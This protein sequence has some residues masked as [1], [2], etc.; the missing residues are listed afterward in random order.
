MTYEIVTKGLCAGY[1]KQKV[2]GDV[3]LSLPSG[4]IA[5]LAGP[6]GSGKTT[7]LKTIVGQL[8]R[9]EGTVILGGRELAEFGGEE[10]AKEAS[11]VLTGRVRPELMKCFDVAAA[12]RYPHTGRFGKLGAE[13]RRQVERAMEQLHV[14]E[15]ADRYFDTLSDGQKQRVLI[16]RALCQQPKL[17]VMDEPMNYLDVR[18]QLDL[19]DLLRELAHG[20]GMTIMLSL[21]EI[22]LAR[23]IA[24]V[25]LL[26][27]KDH[28]VRF[29]PAEQVLSRGSLKE[30]FSLDDKGY[31]CYFHD[32]ALPERKKD[33]KAAHIPAETNVQ[34]NTSSVQNTARVLMV[35]GTMSGVGKSLLAAG[36]CRIFAADGFRAAPFKSQNMALNSYVTEDGLEIGR[37]QAMQALAAGQKPVA[38]MNPVL[39]KP[40]GHTGSQVIV[41]GRVRGDME[42][43]EY[44][45]FRQKLMPEIIEAFTR[46]AKD[47]DIIVVEG[48]GSPAELN[49]KEGD[50]VNMGLAQLIDAPVLLVGDIDRGGIFAQ[51]LGTLELLEPEERR[52]VRGL[53]V[54]KFR[55]DPALFADGVRILEERSSLP[56]VGVVPFTELQL[57]DEDSLNPRFER[58]GRGRIDLAVVRFPRISNA[59]DFDVFEQSPEVSVRYVRT[60]EELRGADMIFLPGSKNT[61]D[62]LRWF[63][64]SGLFAAVREKAEEGTPLWG[65]C[66]G[67]Q[68]LGESVEDPL[69]AEAGGTA[70]GL[71]LLPVVT[72]LEKEKAQTQREG[73]LPPVGGMFAALS[74]KAYKGYEIHMGR[75]RFSDGADGPLPVVVER[76]GNIF[77]TYLHGVFDAEGIAGA[78]LEALAKRKGIR[79]DASLLPRDLARE[80]EFDRLEACLRDNLPMDVIYR[81]MGMEP[82]Q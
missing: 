31:E 52:R 22:R 23:K 24:D 60:P 54:N 53:I 45:A 27:R 73:V 28:V 38:D 41:N 74:Q 7:L 72:T 44:F 66:G 2:V 40:T 56:V 62:D 49:L 5:V 47:N 70:K 61:L 82:P 37:A 80:R 75:T 8:E 78:I 14:L 76:R 11:V 79:V 36:L 18:Y 69:A 3:S 20:Q 1:G 64:E 50:V 35:Q 34:K 51:L 13:D 32:G 15:Y 67:F 42:A 12:G 55:G 16:A 43:G 81:M 68:M 30:L 71:G 17:L 21:H 4:R 46:L 10:L 33:V 77:G 39:L 6:N 19:L 29:G 58:R 26:V 59:S 9:L 57:E 25:A 63:R 48:A 65:I